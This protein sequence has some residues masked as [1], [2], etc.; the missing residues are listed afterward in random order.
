MSCQ[1]PGLPQVAGVAQSLRSGS[2]YN[3]SMMQV[4]L[5]EESRRPNEI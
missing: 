3:S 1:W 2:A 5:L 4:A